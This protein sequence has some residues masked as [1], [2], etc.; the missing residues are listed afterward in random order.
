MR[1]WLKTARDLF[2]FI[3]EA[4]LGPRTPKEPKPFHPQNLLGLHPIPAE[5][6]PEQRVLTRT[7]FTMARPPA[8][9][10][11]QRG[12]LRPKTGDV[13]VAEYLEDV[14]RL[15]RAIRAHDSFAAEEAWDRFERWITAIPI[16]KEGN[17]AHD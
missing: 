1:T 16:T 10:D 11:G 9:Q 12:M 6:R 7:G 2:D 3:A 5:L 15:R 14:S 4:S 8:S 17:E 13:P